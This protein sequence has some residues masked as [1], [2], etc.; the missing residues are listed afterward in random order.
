MSLMRLLV[1]MMT[2]SEMLAISLIHM[3]TMR[4]SG[5]LNSR[6]MY[7]PTQLQLNVKVKDSNCSNRLLGFTDSVYY[8]LMLLQVNIAVFVLIV[9]YVF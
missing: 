4:R 9:T 1:T 7:F 2:S 6:K 5:I 3:Y 8:S